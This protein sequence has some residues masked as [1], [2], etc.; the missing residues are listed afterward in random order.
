MTPDEL[1]AEHMRS[2]PGCIAA[3][4]VNIETGTLVAQRCEGDCFRHLERSAAQVP[5]LFAVDPF[6]FTEASPEGRNEVL[7]LS[8]NRLHLFRRS[9]DPR[10]VLLSISDITSNLGLVLSKSRMEMPA[11][12]A[13]A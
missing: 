2:I 8:N 4:V 13:S 6:E 10:F 11:L 5:K 12:R 1:T 3:A 7:V 9:E